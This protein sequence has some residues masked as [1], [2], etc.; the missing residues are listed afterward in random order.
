M[1]FHPCHFPFPAVATCQCVCVL[2]SHLDWDGLTGC[3]ILDGRLSYSCRLE[4]KLTGRLWPGLQGSVDAGVNE[5]SQCKQ[6]LMS[7]QRETL[8]RSVSGA[9]GKLPHIV[10]LPHFL[11]FPCRPL[12][13]SSWLSQGSCK[14][15]TCQFVYFFFYSRHKDIKR[16]SEVGLQTQIRVFRV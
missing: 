13:T 12:F 2:T 15:K 10:S 16:L 1:I 14:S 4:V 7:L 6:S 5:G 9:A 11:R 8:R 3:C